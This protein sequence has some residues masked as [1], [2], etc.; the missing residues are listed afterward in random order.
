MKFASARQ[1]MAMIVVS[2]AFLYALDYWKNPQLWHEEA[3]APTGEQGQA[4]AAGLT[5][6]MNGASSLAEARQ[7]LAGVEGIDLARAAAPADGS[8]NA[9]NRTAVTIPITDIAKLD[10]VALD[11]T[12]R[13]NGLVAGRMELS[14]LQHFALEAEFPHL[15]SQLTDQSVEERMGYVKTLGMGNLL[16]WVDSVNMSS[17]HK[18]L[19]VYARYLEGGKS[20]DV[21]ELLAGL[22]QVGLSP[23]SLRVVIGE[24]SA[25][26]R[27]SHSDEAH[28]HTHSHTEKE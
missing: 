8:S 12:L 15:S 18:A 28:P 20:V 21:A 22:N 2:A 16:E 3:A 26:G 11:R 6:W 1:I 4:E 5:L 27:S 24:P 17:E 7:A 13:R 10:F 14:G 25:Y 23:D 19:T 9:E